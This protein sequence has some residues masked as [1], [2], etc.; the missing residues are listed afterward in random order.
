MRAQTGVVIQPLK[1]N[2]VMLWAPAMLI[3]LGALAEIIPALKAYRTDVA[4]NL[5]LLILEMKLQLTIFIRLTLAAG[6]FCG[7]S[8]SKNGGGERHAAP[9]RGSTA[10]RRD[11]RSILAGIYHLESAG[12]RERDIAGV[13][14]DGEMEE[15]I[16]SSSESF[17]V[18]AQV[19][20]GEEKLEFAAVANRATGEL[21]ATLRCSRR[22]PTGSRP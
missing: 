11:D 20:G 10:A 19:G 3:A 7:C 1:F 2:A 6:F 13:R 22:M 17:E 14:A 5:Q 8:K 4:E 9:A 18:T 16:H 21:S 12:C 15:F